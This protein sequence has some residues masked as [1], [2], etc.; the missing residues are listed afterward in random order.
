MQQQYESFQQ[1]SL[2]STAAGAKRR[3]VSAPAAPQ[4]AKPIASGAGSVGAAAPAAAGNAAARKRVRRTAAD[5]AATEVGNTGPPPRQPLK[6]AHQNQQPVPQP[7]NSASVGCPAGSHAGGSRRSG[8]QPAPGLKAVVGHAARRLM[9]ASDQPQQSKQQ[10]KTG[11]AGL[12]AERALGLGTSRSRI[13]KDSAGMLQPGRFGGSQE[14]NSSVFTG[15]SSRQQ[16]KLGSQREL[17][18][19]ITF[20]AAAAASIG[21]STADPA[22]EGGTAPAPAAAATQLSDQEVHTT[23]EAKDSEH[24]PAPQHNQQHKPSSGVTDCL[25][26]ANLD[27]NAAADFVIAAVKSELERLSAG[28]KR[29]GSLRSKHVAT[30]KEDLSRSALCRVM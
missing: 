16:Q 3:E 7:A 18:P 20:V 11:T 21:C 25:L 8:S 19:P 23:C 27:D 14:P 6:A 26:T 22:I 24:Q 12:V 17:I 1:T 2:K 9:A 10:R 29:D 4:E 5:R 13:G 28:R 15:C 30:L